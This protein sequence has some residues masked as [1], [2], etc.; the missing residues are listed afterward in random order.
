MMIVD[1]EG[2]T[3]DRILSQEVR[4]DGNKISGTQEGEVQITE[5]GMAV[6]KLGGEEVKGQF[7]PQWDDYTEKQTITF[8]GLTSEGKSIQ[9]VRK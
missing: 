8:T 2:I 3:S 6:I 5:D 4:I 1:Q 7:L 9:L